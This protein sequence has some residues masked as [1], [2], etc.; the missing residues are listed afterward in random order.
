[1]EPVNSLC[2]RRATAGSR[3]FTSRDTTCL[4]RWARLDTRACPI[5]PFAPVMR[6]TGLR[7]GGLRYYRYKPLMEYRSV[8]KCIA[9]CDG[10]YDL[11]QP[12]YR[13]PKCGDLL[14]VAHD[15]TA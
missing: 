1:M 7:M 5:S 11:E 6:T 8:F 10:E 15:M 9:G 14:E 2:T 12:L 3:A 13:C 4:F